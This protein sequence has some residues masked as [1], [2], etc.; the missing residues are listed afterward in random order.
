MEDHPAQVGQAEI[1]QPGAPS[2]AVG[3]ELRAKIQA[4][5]TKLGAESEKLRE[6]ARSLRFTHWTEFS[7][8]VGAV[9]SGLTVIAAVWVGY[10]Q[11]TQARQDRIDRL[12]RETRGVFA[13]IV[14]DLASDNA[15]LRLSATINITPFLENREYRSRVISLLVSAVTREPDAAVRSALEDAMVGAGNDVLG[16]LDRQ[17]EAVLNELKPMFTTPRQTEAEWKDIKTRQAGLFSLAVVQSRVTG[18]PIALRG[19]ELKCFQ[20]IER[21]LERA[22]LQ[23]AALWGADLWRAVLKSAILRGADLTSA[24]LFGAD[25][26]EADLA[27]ADFES[28]NIE[29]GDFRGAKN[30]D[31]T[32]FRAANW[33]L[34]RFDRQIL[35]LLETAYPKGGLKQEGETREE[36]CRPAKR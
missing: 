29:E 7:K 10:N 4:E 33:R 20:L 34:G 23:D 19:A 27:G 2:P 17:R 3:E 18:K 5:T 35:S 21:S 36:L 1:G 32:M 22:D 11:L 13:T 9:L 15:G 12:E 6:E 16:A 26:S 8:A 31:V 30:L 25:L 24:D 14:K 28:A